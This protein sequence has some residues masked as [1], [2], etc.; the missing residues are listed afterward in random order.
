MPV[1]SDMQLEEMIHA[2]TSTYALRNDLPI[3]HTSDSSRNI[4]HACTG[5]SAVS[6]AAAFCTHA[7]CNGWNDLHTCAGKC[8]ARDDWC[9]GGRGC[10]TCSM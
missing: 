3:L 7:A 2:F 9:E 1:E 6:D 4:L 5:G 8:A 10:R